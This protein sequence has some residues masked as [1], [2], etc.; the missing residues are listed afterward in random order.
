MTGLVVLAKWST[1]AGPAETRDCGPLDRSLAAALQGQH[2]ELEKTGRNVVK[3]C[4]VFTQ[5]VPLIDGEPVWMLAEPLERVPTWLFN[6][7]QGVMF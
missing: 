4:Q 1:D 6:V 3:L 2:D 7:K 5:K